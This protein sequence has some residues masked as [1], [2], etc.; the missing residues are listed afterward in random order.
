MYVNNK[1]NY[2]Y[3][4]GCLLI[5]LAMLFLLF[6]TNYTVSSDGAVRYNALV[7]LFKTHSV[8][9]IKYSMISTLFASPLYLISDKL[10]KYFNI[11]VF[12]ITL[13]I[14]SRIISKHFNLDFTIKFIL[15]IL[16]GSLFT[17]YTRDFWSEVFSAS[18]LFLGL[19]FIIFEEK[20]TIGIVLISLAAANIPA[21]LVPVGLLSVYLVVKKRNIVYFLIPAIS[22]SLIILE[23]YIKYKGF[24]NSGYSGDHGYKTLLPYSGLPGFSYPFILGVLSIV[25]SFG[26]GL[27]FYTGGLFFLPNTSNTT[28]SNIFFTSLILIVGGL[29]I[30]YA[31]WWAWY[32]GICFGPRFFLFVS[33]PSAIFL[34]YC[35]SQKSMKISNLELILVML[36]VFLSLYVGFIGHIDNGQYIALGVKNNY[37]LESLSWYIP[38]FSALI[39]PIIFQSEHIYQNLGFLILSLVVYIYL[40]KDLMPNIL[41]NIKN[42]IKKRKLVK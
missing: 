1:L 22:L 36:F 37:A 42:I 32:G 17:N 23:N 19:L 30:V 24:I 26:K 38:E 3:F 40:I 16:I 41:L 13:V 2:N 15:L 28:K 4:I 33:Y 11:I 39:Y 21:L 5:I 12:F 25:F 6:S 8:P 7:E 31:K 29:I 9:K 27:L 18:F 10:V 14:S 35:L 20:R 34:A